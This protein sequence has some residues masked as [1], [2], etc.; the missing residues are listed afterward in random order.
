MRSAKAAALPAAVFFCLATAGVFACKQRS[1]PAEVKATPEDRKVI[2]AAVPLAADDVT[3]DEK[4]LATLKGRRD[5]AWKVVEQVLRPVRIGAEGGLKGF[6][7]E[8]E[9]T[10][11]LW[12]TWYDAGEFLELFKRLYM[13]L[14]KEGRAAKK[15]FCPAAVQDAFS[16]HATKSLKGWTPEK[17]EQRLGQLKSQ[18][19]V[20]GVSGKGV[21]LFSPG[22][23]T[24]LFTNY[25]GISKCPET[26][27]TVERQTPPPA[28]PSFSHCLAAEF[29]NGKE[30]ALA[31]D[32]VAYAHCPEVPR[33]KA[34]LDYARSGISVAV[35]TAW[36]VAH[37]E[38]LAAFDTTAM[39]LGRQLEDG[40]W[41]PARMKTDGDL[42]PSNIYTIRLKPSEREYWLVGLHLAVKSLRHWMW[43]T[44][45]WSDD[46]DQDFGADRPDELK[47][48]GAWG[49][50]KMCVTT[51]FKEQDPDPAAAY[52][53]SAPSLAAA[54]RAYGKRDPDASWCSNPYV[55]LGHGNAR[56]NCIG[57][58]QHAGGGV[59]A[60]DDVFLDEPADAANAARRAR[61]PHDGRSAVR[62]NFPSDYLWSITQ[63][64]DFFA[65]KI[66][67]KAY[68]MDL[69]DK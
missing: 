25:N 5:A 57:C 54:V 69:S 63:S 39:A 11:P 15:P 53:G 18:P 35:K 31:L 4:D 49:H 10:L 43:I 20:H 23:L 21:T 8:D 48:S 17:L 26:T 33:E 1:S 47:A 42:S 19:E 16:A 46:P 2:G 65:T 66:R 36:N 64:P 34:A 6:R 7:P 3:F 44:L 27:K 51:D 38:D 41:V 24:G 22:I 12:Q 40:A 45:W 32:A 37:R 68:E 62:I 9:A 61:Y 13:G 28:G 67:G 56:T 30:S 60:P 14:G 52:D 55:E 58:H 59:E 50:Y 29:P